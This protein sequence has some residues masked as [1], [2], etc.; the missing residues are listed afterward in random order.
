M[1][2]YS[3]YFPIVAGVVGLGTLCS[4]A[5]HAAD[6]SDSSSVS[7]M[8]EMVVEGQQT[9]ESAYQPKS[10]TFG[11]LGSQSLQDM[12]FSTTVL[13]QELLNDRQVSSL[14]EALQYD[15]ST[16]IEARGGMDVGRP[17]SRGMEGSVVDNF[18]IDGMNAVATT[19]Q[20][21]ELYQRVEVIH[22]LTG[23]LY[24]PASPA[25][26]FNLELKRP[27]KNYFNSV[28]ASVTG[29]GTRLLHVDVGG[30][31]IKYAG[32]RFNVLKEQGEGYVS[33]S[34]VNR[35]LFG[36]AIDLH[37]TDSTTLELN[38]SY[39]RF[40]R[41]G[42]PG[43]F[44]YSPT[45]GLPHALDA[46]K[47]GYGQSWAGNSLETTMESA[48]LKQ[49]FGKNWN[50]TAGI[51]HQIARRTMRSV[52]NTFNNDGTTMDTSFNVNGATTVHFSITSN[53]A[54]VN[55]TFYTGDIQHDVV[56]GTSGYIWN[57]Y[58]AAGGRSYVG[59]GSSPI[60]HPQ[61]YSEVAGNGSLP[62][63]LASHN[64]AQAGI[65]GDTITW[66]R[67]FSTLLM[68]SYNYFSSEGYNA[69][70]AH[71]GHYVDNGFSSNVAFMYK[72]ISNVTTYIA[73]GD[74]LE[75]G[76]T[77]PDTA[78]NSGTS[79]S[80]VRSRQTEIGVKAQLG[81]VFTRFAVF[82]ITRPMAFTGEDHYYREQGKQRNNGAEL[83]VQGAVTSQ[84]DVMGGVTY[85]D[86]TLKDGYRHNVSN[87]RVVGI[88][89]YQANVLANY[90]FMALPGFSVNT[91]VHYVS[92]RAA[93]ATNE[94]W[95]GSYTTLDLGAKYVT[96]KIY[97]KK[98]TVRLNATNLFDRKYW[99]AFFPRNEY[100][101]SA[102]NTAFLGE[103][104]QLRLS[105]TIEF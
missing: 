89:R 46:G 85:L 82:H 1:D 80:P 90:K 37:L 73:H 34:W 44:S 84:L 87:K 27:T 5:V 54:R 6:V 97:G 30:T 53:V 93:D 22:S 61:S 101:S 57:V 7:S 4:P 104:R 12:P 67:Y 42:F 78:L 60:D 47:K 79:L 62:L 11:P 32:Y 18:H 91:N 83:N 48:K 70:G 69:G 40:I 15:P 55:G 52:G 33:D 21:I 29:D 74:T 98:L 66:N 23:A 51:L 88:P 14:G 94:V 28:R 96:N 71:T 105:G 17:Q 77:A 16:Q 24:G 58:N 68:G 81:G 103:P 75:Q 41:M 64:R 56:A 10:A 8:P 50:L 92:K 35:K 38:G 63:Y 72:P 19:A 2:K 86:A 95:A 13:N 9:Q 25:G 36:G 31:P 3:A 65:L 43:G 100:G 49:Q 76:G 59:L 26:D 45:S 99:A 102:T 39:Y 20:P